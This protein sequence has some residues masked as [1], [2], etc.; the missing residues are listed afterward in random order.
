LRCA[1]TPTASAAGAAGWRSWLAHQFGTPMAVVDRTL[2]WSMHF[3]DPDA[4]PYEITCCDQQA[5][6]GG[7][8]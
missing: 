6:V 3:R 7:V 1:S 4:N 5:A 2:S 8:S